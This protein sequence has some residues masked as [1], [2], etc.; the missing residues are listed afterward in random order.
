[1]RNSTRDALRRRQE[2]MA[3]T[4]ESAAFPAHLKARFANVK[5]RALALLARR[6][7]G[8]PQLGPELL[9]PVREEQRAGERHEREAGEHH[10]CRVE[11]AGALVK[12]AEERHR[13][14]RPEQSDE[15]A[16][17]VN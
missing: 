11:A 16:H 14:S 5:S 17:R 10:D 9:R 2:K 6:R 3:A 1:M 7:H 15:E 12:E 4:G 8:A 13:A